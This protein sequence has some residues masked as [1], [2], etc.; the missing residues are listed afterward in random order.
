MGQK[1]KEIN[2]EIIAW[3]YMRPGFIWLLHMSCL[4]HRSTFI[5]AV[6][7]AKKILKKEEICYNLTPAA[8]HRHKCDNDLTRSFSYTHGLLKMSHTADPA[9]DLFGYIHFHVDCYHLQFTASP[10]KI[11]TKW[12][13]WKF[14]QCSRTLKKLC[15]QSCFNVK[16]VFW[17][18]S[19]VWKKGDKLWVNSLFEIVLPIP[20]QGA[21][22]YLCTV[23]ANQLP[24]RI[25]HLYPPPKQWQEIGES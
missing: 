18:V 1:P 16:K 21:A 8:F 9:S 4:N 12:R 23:P 5:T 22:S 17:K 25:T 6:S 13:G 2:N 14:T 20:Q 24:V 15:T 10:N 7:S 11:P 3:T 19:L